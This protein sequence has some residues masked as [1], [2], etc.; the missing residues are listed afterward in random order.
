MIIRRY[1]HPLKDKQLDTLILGCTHYPLLS[2]LIQPRIGKRVKLIDSSET[3][4]L[5]VRDYLNNHP[6]LVK[7]SLAEP[8]DNQFF[9]SDLNDSAQQMADNIFKRPIDLIEIGTT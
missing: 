4:A 3:T 1:L 7:K 9:V 8:S 2:K 5:Y 6:D